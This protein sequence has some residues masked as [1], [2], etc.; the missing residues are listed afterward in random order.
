MPGIRKYKGQVVPQIEASVE[1]A[2]SAERSH[3]NAA[4]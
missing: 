3:S 1:P 4:A 2:A